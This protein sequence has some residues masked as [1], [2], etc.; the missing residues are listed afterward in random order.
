MLANRRVCVSGAQLEAVIGYFTWSVLVRREA[1]SMIHSCSSFTRC[2]RS[3]IIPLPPDVIN[4]LCCM[5]GMLPLLEAQCDLPRSG[6]ITC[7]DASDAGLGVCGKFVAPSTVGDVGRVFEKLRLVT[8]DRV[9][10][11][12]LALD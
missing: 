1:L 2:F 12:A 3:A 9:R 7:T 8:E 6:R 11:R 10:A 4:E 5:Q